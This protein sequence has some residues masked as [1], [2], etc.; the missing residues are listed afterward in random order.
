[1]YDNYYIS[2]LISFTN[3]TPRTHFIQILTISDNYRVHSWPLTTTTGI[4]SWFICHIMKRRTMVHDQKSIA[5]N[6]LVVSPSSI[7]HYML[8]FDQSANNE[9]SKSYRWKKI[10]YLTVCSSNHLDS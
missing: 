9:K 2:T 6:K 5:M 8:N 3:T 1:M 4:C 7:Y 10:K